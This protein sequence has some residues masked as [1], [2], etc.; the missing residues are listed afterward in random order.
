MIGP[1]NRSNLAT[2]LSDKPFLPKLHFPLLPVIQASLPLLNPRY[3]SLFL[4]PD[5]L[6]PSYPR[7]SSSLSPQIHFPLRTSPDK[8]LP[9]LTPDTLPPS[10]SRYTS[11][12]LTQI[13]IP[14]FLPRTHFPLAPVVQMLDSA[15]QQ[16]N[17]F[18]LPTIH[19]SPSPQMQNLYLR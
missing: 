9:L 8:H 16:I 18:P 6:T 4:T 14:H 5:T 13:N 7:N 2:A 10:F 3:T 1:T 19:T 11:P 15:M 17:T 12:F